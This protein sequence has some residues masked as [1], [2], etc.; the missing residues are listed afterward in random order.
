M[1]CRRNFRNVS[2]LL[3]FSTSCGDHVLPT[4]KGFDQYILICEATQSNAKNEREAL[5]M[6]LSNEIHAIHYQLVSDTSR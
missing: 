4:G 2:M 3:I 1:S 5:A 6:A